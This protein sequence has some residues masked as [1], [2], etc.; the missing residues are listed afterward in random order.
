MKPVL[1]ITGV[2]GTG[3]TTISRLLQEKLDATHIDVTKLAIRERDTQKTDEKRETLIVNMKTLSEK[4]VDLIDK[5]RKLVII[6]GHYSPE[7]IQTDLVEKIFVLRRAPWVI[8]EV[9]EKRGYSTTKIMENIE[10]EILGTCLHDALSHHPKEVICEIDVT[11]ISS[12]F[13]AELITSILAENKICKVYEI[14]WG[15]HIKTL[16]IL[17]ELKCNI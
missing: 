10:A 8:K 1:I 2:P 17:K 4:L 6:D 9:L 11:D 5:S 12:D 15:T 16:E 7:L 13:T 14:D 3:K